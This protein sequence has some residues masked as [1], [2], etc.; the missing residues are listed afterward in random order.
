M[1][2]PTNK[3]DR[4]EPIMK[5]ARQIAELAAGETPETAQGI[6]DAIASCASVLLGTKA[7][8]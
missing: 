8:A 7:P 5:M 2:T 1:S 4:S 3:A 6:V